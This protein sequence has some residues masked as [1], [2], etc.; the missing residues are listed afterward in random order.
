MADEIQDYLFGPSLKVFGLM[1]RV[2]NYPASFACMY[3]YSDTGTMGGEGLE[4]LYLLEVVIP[5]FCK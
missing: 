1:Q 3:S 4:G 5:D 2:P